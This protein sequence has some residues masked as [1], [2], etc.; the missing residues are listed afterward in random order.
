MI[1]KDVI[2]KFIISAILVQLYFSLASLIL[3]KLKG[4]CLHVHHLIFIIEKFSKLWDGP[5]GQL[6]IILVVDQV[7][8]GLF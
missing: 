4:A 8:D 1:K 2:K 7:D 5:C 6:G 3:H